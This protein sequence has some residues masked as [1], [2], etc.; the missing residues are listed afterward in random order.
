MEHKKLYKIIPCSYQFLSK[1]VKNALDIQNYMFK[2]TARNY[3]I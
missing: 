1:Q 2:K 3:R